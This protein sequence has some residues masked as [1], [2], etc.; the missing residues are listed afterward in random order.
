MD[1]I[2]QKGTIDV[3]LSD[4]L[5]IYIIV[6]KCRR[7]KQI[8]RVKGWILKKYDKNKFQQRVQ[9]DP[10]W[11]SF[12]AN[13]DVNTKWTIFYNIV[14]DSAD[15]FCP[16]VSMKLDTE[17]DGWLT[18]EVLEAI[19]ETNRLFKIAKFKNTRNDWNIFKTQRK[20]ARN[21]LLN[22]K[23]EFLNNQLE[24]NR[25]NPRS[26]WRKLNNIIGNSKGRQCF[27][28]VFNDNGKK[29]EN[30]EGAEFMNN[31]FTTIGEELNMNNGTN[32][33]THQLFPYFPANIFFLNVVEEDVVRK[34]VN[35]L[36]IS[37]PSGMSNLNN[38]VKSR[39]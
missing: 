35:K 28:S 31:Y 39:L 15:S 33:M 23:E 1:N 16:K 10:R 27:T 19:M 25:N 14:N 12:W 5:P 2:L 38:T 13:N 6:K 34:Y 36:D 24:E 8:V 22:T 32:W 18:K 3:G 37:K 29:V 21:L 26:F 20:Y 7:I 9:N 30:E 11:K 17:N 4:H